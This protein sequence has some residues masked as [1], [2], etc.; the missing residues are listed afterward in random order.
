M[1]KTASVAMLAVKY[2]NKS[3]EME[4]FDFV[5][6]IRLKY[7]EKEMSLPEVIVKQHDKLKSQ[8]IGQIRAILEGKTKHRVA[9]LLDGY[10]EYKKGTNTEI[11]EAIRS[12]VGNCF[13]LLTSRPGYV[14]KCTR[15]RMDGEVRIEGFNNENIKKCCD[16]YL[17]ARQRTDKLL[18]LAKEA[19]IS[20]ANLLRVPII[21]LMTCVIFD[22]KQSLPKTKT[23]IIRTIIELMMDRSTLKHYGCKSSDLE[24]LDTLLETLGKIS[25]TALQ[26]DIGQ[27]L[28]KK[29]DSFFT[30]ISVMEQQNLKILQSDFLLLV[31]Q[32]EIDAASEDIMK[33]G[34]LSVSGSDSMSITELPTF[35]SYGHKLLQEWCGAYFIEKNL[36][37]V[38]DSN[39]CPCDF[40]LQSYSL[41]LCCCHISKH[42]RQ[43]I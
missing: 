10:D 32:E 9:L 38:S 43:N 6:T 31:L 40:L 35:V 36:Q 12:G 42:K 34:L 22:E 20:E 16:L 13:L 33:L 14:E 37:K 7:A 17:G 1:G 23:E 29:V 28:L 4:N 8:H 3:E 25:W 5:F 41:Y 27:L 26:N 19:G 24:H 21:L 2:A 15:D 18:Q 39:L 11:D 30:G